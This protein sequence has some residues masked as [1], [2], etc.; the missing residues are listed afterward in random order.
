[1][2]PDRI[3][4][5]EV[6]GGEAFDLLQALNTGHDGSLTTVHANGVDAVV[7]RITGLVLMAGTGIPVSAAELQLAAAV[8]FVVHV[9]RRQGARRVE[10]VGEVRRHGERVDVEPIFATV[11]GALRAVGTPV[12]ALRRPDAPRPDAAWFA[13]CG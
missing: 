5:G 11:D 13:C 8:D 7:D 3:V 6:R 9:A 2:R 10:T 12:R 4:V 1:M